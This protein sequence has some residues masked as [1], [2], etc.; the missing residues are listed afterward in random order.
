M[1]KNIGTLQEN[2]VRN[3]L[4]TQYIG[5]DFHFFEETTSTFDM[6]EKIAIKNGSVICARRQTNGRG[7]L[8]RS[9]ESQNGGIYFSFIA[10]V[11]RNSALLE[12]FFRSL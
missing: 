7:R 6:A 12:R 11:W 1:D 3:M 2:L 10:I 5:K 8:G 9:W 4:K